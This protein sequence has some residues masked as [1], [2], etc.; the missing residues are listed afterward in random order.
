MVF[1]GIGGILRMILESVKNIYFSSEHNLDNELFLPIVQ[2]SKS[3][4]CMSGYFTSNVLAELSKSF[5]HF[6]NANVGDIKFI[7]SPNL[8]EQDLSAIKKAIDAN[9]NIIPF[10]FPDFE[11]TESELKINAVNVLAYLVAT[12][13]LTLKI[14]LQNKGLFHTKCW[15]FETAFGCI[16]VHGSINATQAAM[17]VNFEQI[18][19]NKSWEGQTSKSVVDKISDTFEKIW[20]KNYAGIS[21]VSLNKKSIDFLMHVNEQLAHDPIQINTLLMEKLTDLT[22]HEMALE[23]IPQTLTIPYWLNYTSGDFEHQ[24]KAIK[25]WLKNQGRGI[26]AIAT[27]GGKTLTALVAASLVLTNESSLLIVIA[28]PTLALLNQWADDVKSFGV[29]PI[30]TQGIPAAE[31][32]QVF[33]SCLRRLKLGVS[34]CEVFVATHESLK[35][36]RFIKLLEKAA[37]RMPTMLIGDEVHNLGSIGFQS[38]ATQTFKYRLG[39]SATFVRQFDEVGTQFLLDYF[40]DV[41]FEFNLENAIGICLVPFDYHVHQ[42]TLDEQEEIEWAELTHSIKKLSYASNLPDGAQDKERWERLCLKRRRIVESAA[43]KVS[44]LA[45]ILPERAAI[46]RT[47][48]FCTDK[49]PEQIQ[50]VNELLNNKHILFHQITAEETANKKKLADLIHGFDTEELQV[51]TSKRVLDEGFN[52]PQTETAFLLA[53]NTVKRQ[54]IQRLGRVLRKSNKTNKTKAIIHDF[55]VIPSLTNGSIDLDLKSLIRSELSRVQFFD[56]LCLNGL[57]KGGT[58]DVIELLLTLLDG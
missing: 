48:I 18:A 32:G 11:L 13:K 31:L 47:L 51:L 10:L 22:E 15:L 23:H 19:V 6:V 27:G 16:A 40:G 39:L 1:S 44:M 12:K 54:W 5:F 14:A 33:N 58:A 35:S 52:I 26:L 30:N 2:H 38:A 9:E 53:S 36:E 17:S 25:A 24:G 49:Y 56:S 55:V 42:V 21:T 57:E 41:V 50:K 37:V 4:R 29:E 28:V 45:S 3:I 20:E 34:K 8:S 7:I 43:G 46:N